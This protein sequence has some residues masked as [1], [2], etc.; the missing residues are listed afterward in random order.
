MRR[1][2]IGTAAFLAV[3]GLVVAG[4]LLLRPPPREIRT[5]EDTFRYSFTVRNTSNELLHQ[6]VFVAYAPAG[7]PFAQELLSLTATAD[8]RLE[9]DDLGNRIMTFDL[10]TLPPFGAR[11]ITVTA[12]LRR[13]AQFEGQVLHLNIG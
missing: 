2:L 4:W 1:K 7:I 6:P 12:R 3:L 11:V 10:E 8:F 13:Q 9:T 5:F